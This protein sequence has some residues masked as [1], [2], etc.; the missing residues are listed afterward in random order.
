VLNLSIIQFVNKFVF[1]GSAA[2][3]IAADL[4]DPA[5]GD[6]DALKKAKND[7]HELFAEKIKVTAT[8]AM[9]EEIEKK[10]TEAGKLSDDDKHSEEKK[11]TLKSEVLILKLNLIK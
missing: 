3:K 2:E 5:K 1:Q 9:K 7:F 6:G 11:K 10:V 4:I 8:K